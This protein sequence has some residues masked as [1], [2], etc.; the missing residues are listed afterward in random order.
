MHWILIIWLGGGYQGYGAIDHISFAT[1]EA[2][3]EALTTWDGKGFC[4][5][6]GTP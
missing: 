3:Q 4:T 2:C 1:K 5:Q 6:D